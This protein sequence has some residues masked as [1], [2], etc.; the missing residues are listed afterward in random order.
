MPLFYCMQCY[1]LIRIKRDV[2]TVNAN[3]LHEYNYIYNRVSNMRLQVNYVVTIQ[4]KFIANKVDQPTHLRRGFW[5]VYTLFS[6]H[7][8][9]IKDSRKHIICHSVSSAEN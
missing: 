8:I 9:Y 2:K 6:V 7:Q 4:T 1:L 3:I 5:F